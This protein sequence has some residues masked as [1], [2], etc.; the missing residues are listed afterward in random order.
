MRKFL[1][2]MI[3]ALAFA[4]PVLANVGDVFSIGNTQFLIMQRNYDDQTGM[5]TFALMCTQTGAICVVSSGGF[6]P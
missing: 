1:A 4:A 5:T 2:A 6:T 3:L